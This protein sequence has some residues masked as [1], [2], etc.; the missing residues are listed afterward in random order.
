MQYVLPPLQSCICLLQY[1][2]TSAHFPLVTE[3]D[4]PLSAYF[5]TSSSVRTC[6]S[7]SGSKVAKGRRSILAFAIRP[8][9][10]MATG[11]VHAKSFTPMLHH[12]ALVWPVC[13]WFVDPKLL[14]PLRTIFLSPPAPA[15]HA[16]RYPYSPL[17]PSSFPRSLARLPFP[18]SHFSP[19][20]HLSLAPRSMQLETK[21]YPRSRHFLA[22]PQTMKG[23]PRWR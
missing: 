7:A 1:V 9:D 17:L 12:F 13:C 3:P 20:Q 22:P 6:S 5:S 21:L 2:Q 11:T 15:T 16:V 14:V 4:F 10:S 19:S 23:H 18:T 8:L